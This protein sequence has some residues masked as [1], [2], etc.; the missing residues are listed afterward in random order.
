MFV[1]EDKKGQHYYSLI[2]YISQREYRKRSE[3]GSNVNV[4]GEPGDTFSSVSY[5]KHLSLTSVSALSNWTSEEVADCSNKAFIWCNTGT[6]SFHLLSAELSKENVKEQGA[7]CGEQKNRWKTLTFSSQLHSRASALGLC[8][9]HCSEPSS[10]LKTSNPPA[11][12]GRGLLRTAKAQPQR[13]WKQQLQALNLQ[14]AAATLPVVPNVP[15]NIS[16][17]L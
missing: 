6:V 17:I 14:H 3:A 9:V 7:A 1:K 12:S 2:F 5:Q 16:H 15:R 4:W 11:K 8:G 10:G 13:T